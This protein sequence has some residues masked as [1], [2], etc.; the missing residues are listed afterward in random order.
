MK[1]LVF[2]ICLIT[3]FVISYAQT[4]AQAKYADLITVNNLHKHLSII[5]GAEIFKSNSLTFQ[6]RDQVFFAIK[7]CMITSYGYW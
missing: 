7:S 2:I 1:K 6:E 5:A 3:G 4:D